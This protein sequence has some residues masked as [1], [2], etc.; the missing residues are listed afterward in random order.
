[1]ESIALHQRSMGWLK[2]CKYLFFG[3]YSLEGASV[4]N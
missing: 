2:L 3:S 4:A 1:M